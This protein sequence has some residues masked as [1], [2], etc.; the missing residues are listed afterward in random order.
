MA[1]LDVRSTSLTKK[2]WGKL[3]SEISESQCFGLPVGVLVECLPH[4]HEDP[5]LGRPKSGK[6]ETGS[7]GLAVQEV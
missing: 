6:A 1:P 7:Q 3:H 5:S 4:R 2:W